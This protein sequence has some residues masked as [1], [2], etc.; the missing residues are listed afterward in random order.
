MQAFWQNN[1]VPLAPR[2]WYVTKQSLNRVALL[3]HRSIEGGQFGGTE[4]SWF[5]SLLSQKRG[6]I[7]SHLTVRLSV[8]LPVCHK[9]L[10]LIHNFWT[11]GCRAFIIHMYIPCDVAFLFIPVFDLVTLTVTFDLIYL[12]ILTLIAVSFKEGTG[13]FLVMRPFHHPKCFDL[14]TLTVTFDLHTVS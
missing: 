4:I 10:N 14:V 12:K 8:R 3:I 11:I 2:Y 6:D 9:N 5:L 13:S 1:P 7:E